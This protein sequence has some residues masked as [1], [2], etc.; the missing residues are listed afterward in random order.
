MRSGLSPVLSRLIPCCSLS[1][2]LGNPS[3]KK[4]SARCSR[5]CRDPFIV[6]C[7]PLCD[8][9]LFIPCSQVAHGLEPHNFTFLLGYVEERSDPKAKQWH[10]LPAAMKCLKAIWGPNHSVTIIRASCDLSL[11]TCLIPTVSHCSWPLRPSLVCA[12][13]HLSD[14][15]RHPLYCVSGKA[16][17][18]LCLRQIS[19]SLSALLCLRQCSPSFFASTLE[20]AW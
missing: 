10:M 8:A 18:L 19:P 1:T 9:R 4:R 11:H 17:R 12:T 13:S 3:M 6:C 16:L 7:T 5:L 2:A 14:V 15:C 20:V